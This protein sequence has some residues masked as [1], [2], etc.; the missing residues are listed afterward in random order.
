[1]SLPSLF[2]RL[3]ELRI[4][5]QSQTADGA[6]RLH[7]RAEGGLCFRDDFLT[8]NGPALRFDLLVVH[9]EQ[10]AEKDQLCQQRNGHQ[11][12]AL[13]EDGQIVADFAP[14]RRYGLLHV[15]SLL[16]RAEFARFRSARR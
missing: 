3:N 14:S 12:E 9:F 13:L 15:L 7:E 16:K 8:V 1:T 4:A 6:A 5:G 11:K 2:P 10:H